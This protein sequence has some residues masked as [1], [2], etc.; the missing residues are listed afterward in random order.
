MPEVA[1]LDAREHIGHE[2]RAI[3]QR[4]RRRVA[5]RIHAPLGPHGEH[6]EDSRAAGQ[7]H[8]HF[9]ELCETPRLLRLVGR[10]IHEPGGDQQRREQRHDQAGS[11]R[12]L[13]HG[14]HGDRR[15]PEELRQSPQVSVVG[16]PGLRLRQDGIG[17]ERR[18]PEQHAAQPQRIATAQDEHGAAQQDQRHENQPLLERRVV[19]AEALQDAVEFLGRRAEKIRRSRRAVRRGQQM[20]HAD[21]SAHR[22]RGTDAAAAAPVHQPLR[23]AQ[24]AQCGNEHDEARQVREIGRDCTA[25]HPQPATAGG[26]VEELRQ[27]ARRENTERCGEL[28]REIAGEQHVIERH[29][30]G[31]QAGQPCGRTLEAE[32]ARAVDHREG[33]EHGG[34]DRQPLPRQLR[35]HQAHR[36]GAEQVDEHVGREHPVEFVERAELPPVVEQQVADRHRARE[37]V[38][39]VLQGRCSRKPDQHRLRQQDHGQQHADQHRAGSG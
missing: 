7:R 37:M 32:P 10:E 26:P 14:G 3:H 9:A 38:R 36:A 17:P 1:T 31:E 30:R 12:G 21:R 16:H 33:H 5:Q 15:K 19:H 35:A 28:E 39:Q 18:E 8:Q 27:Q 22:Q 23:S 24:R 25:C 11:V 20:Q 34:Q 29:E 6:R 13:Q 4:V 2:R